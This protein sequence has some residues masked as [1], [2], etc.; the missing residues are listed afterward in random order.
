MKMPQG[1]DGHSPFKRFTHIY[2]EGPSPQVLFL[3]RRSLFYFL[4]TS[5]TALTTTRSM[6]KPINRNG[7]CQGDFKIRIKIVYQLYLCS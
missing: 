4:G 6:D 2:L 3:K 7:E 5:I 1:K